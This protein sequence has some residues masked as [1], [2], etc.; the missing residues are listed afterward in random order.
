VSV[1]RDDR[2]WTRRYDHHPET[3]ELVRE[4]KQTAGLRSEIIG[5]QWTAPGE[6]ALVVVGDLARP[7]G[8]LRLMAED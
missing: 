3:A 2:S 4:A 8:F 1:G 5:L 7:V 6:C